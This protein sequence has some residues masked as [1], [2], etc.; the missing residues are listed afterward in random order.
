[1][2]RSSLY[3]SF[4][5]LS[6]IF[7]LVLPN[8]ACQLRDGENSHHNLHSL[9][10]DVQ[11]AYTLKDIIR[12][13]GLYEI[14]PGVPTPLAEDTQ[15]VYTRSGKGGSKSTKKSKSS[16]NGQSTT[17]T[18]PE[19]SSTKSSKQSKSSKSASSKSSGGGN[20]KRPIPMKQEMY[21]RLVQLFLTSC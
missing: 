21:T 18:L 17:Q 8:V 20:G 16:G 5:I 3:S 1:M 15:D 2:L 9:P 7:L 11:E 14:G 10:F 4:S 19:F 12:Y 13:R 6:I